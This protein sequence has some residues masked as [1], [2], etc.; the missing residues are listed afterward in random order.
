MAQAVDDT[1]LHAGCRRLTGKVL[2][3]ADEEAPFGFRHLMRFPAAAHSPVPHRAVNTAGMLEGAA[4]VAL[5]LLPVGDG[6]LPWDRTL[7]L[8]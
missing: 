7:G 3:C 2:A 5:S 4:G 1:E 6:P 8:T